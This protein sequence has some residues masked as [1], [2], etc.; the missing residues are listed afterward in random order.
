M[1]TDC[2]CDPHQA[3]IEATGSSNQ[4]VQ[5][6]RISKRIDDDIL[7]HVDFLQSC[8][9]EIVASLTLE[10]FNTS[11]Y[12]WDWSK[13]GGVRGGFCWIRRATPQGCPWHEGKGQD[14]NLVT[15]PSNGSAISPDSC[16]NSIPWPK[17]SAW[18][19]ALLST[20]PLN[21]ETSE[22][23]IIRSNIIWQ[24]GWLSANQIRA[25]EY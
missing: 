11:L 12:V 21:S 17:A 2:F 23:N 10:Q 14:G 16:L 3:I 15:I 13:C 4:Q 18:T 8:L 9:Y 5:M 22:L 19:A 24:T 1:G 25:T 20:K 7:P 6:C